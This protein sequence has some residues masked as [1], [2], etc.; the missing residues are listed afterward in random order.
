MQ[1]Q[2]EVAEFSRQMTKIGLE[3]GMPSQDADRFGEV[4]VRLRSIGVAM[5]PALVMGMSIIACKGAWHCFTTH[6]KDEK[7]FPDS[8][9][10]R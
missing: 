9:T 6:K 5:E 3:V 7:N 10:N 1:T 4:M 2:G 8:L